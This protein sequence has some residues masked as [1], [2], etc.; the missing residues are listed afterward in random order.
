MYD[1]IISRNLMLFVFVL[2]DYT[3]FKVIPIH[4]LS[5]LILIDILHRKK[6][7]LFPFIHIPPITFFMYRYT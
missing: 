5:F 1:F 3:S 2:F 7:I 6:N 4:F